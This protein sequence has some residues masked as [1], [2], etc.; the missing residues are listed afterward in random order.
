MTTAEASADW[1]ETSDDG[2]FVI[3]GTDMEE[4][5]RRSIGIRWCFHCRKRHNFDRV[6]YAPTGL[7][8]YDPYASIEGINNEC[9]DLFPGWTREWEDD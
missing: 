1:C 3:C 2:S 9:T 8:Y 6:C 4:Y 5:A 7:S